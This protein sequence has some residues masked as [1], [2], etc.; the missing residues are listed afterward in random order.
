MRSWAAPSLAELPGKGEPLRLY[1]RA[2]GAVRGLDL[3]APTSMYVCGI[4]PYD[5]THLGHAFTFVCFDQ[6]LRV[7]RDAGADLHY[8]Q[9]VTDVDDPLLER[10][11]ATGEG[12]R[13]LAD[14]EIELFREDMAALRVLPPEHYVGAVEAIPQVV[15][16]VERL[17][18]AG[19]AYRLEGD[20]YFSVACAPGLGSVSQL[21]YPQMVRLS[22]E[23]GG[24]P[25]REGKK[26]PVDPLLW[27]AARAGEPSWESP[28]GPGR[29]GWHVECAAIAM[30]YLGETIGIQGGGNDLVFPHHELCAAQ[31][32]AVT[33]VPFARA[34]V[35]SGGVGLDGTKMSKSLG[36]M[37]FVSALRAQGVDPGA[38][39]LA[40]LDHHYRSDWSWTP[41]DLAR[42]DGRLTAWRLAAG[43]V[44]G[45]E[46][47]PL[48]AQVRA[49]LAS[50]LDVPAALRAVDRW[51]AQALEGSGRRVASAPSLVVATLDRL[52]GLTIT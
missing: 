39:R 46:S 11:A 20:L 40:L 25:D 41:A 16:L 7:L 42:A 3:S 31:A 1:D 48:L 21:S 9:N 5:A 27:R 37:V 29:P 19:A 4:T 8:V 52:F 14:R 26:D 45:P 12:W 17:L 43:G 23:R 30:H 18:D 28:F 13:A 34:F 22:R 35:H 50:D 10:A 36:N 6:L 15:A 44:D 32:T 49:A 2:A 51:A 24:D 38:L 47:E 33:G